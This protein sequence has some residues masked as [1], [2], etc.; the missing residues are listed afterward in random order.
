MKKNLL[1]TSFVMVF[2]TVIVGITAYN[3]TSD[4]TYSS[5]IITRSVAKGLFWEEI[6]FSID[7]QIERVGVYVVN[8]SLNIQVEIEDL[9]KTIKNRLKSLKYI[10][11]KTSS[12]ELDVEVIESFYENNINQLISQMI[13]EKNKNPQ[14]TNFVAEMETL[15]N[16]NFQI[17]K[18]INTFKT[19]A[20]PKYEQN[21]NQLRYYSQQVTGMITLICV[22]LGIILMAISANHLSTLYEQI[23]KQAKREK[24]ISELTTAVCS[25]FDL[26]VIFD[27]AIKE[28]AK[29]LNFD[30][31][32][33]L[34]Y[35]E[36]RGIGIC[37]EYITSDKLEPETICSIESI[38][39][40]SNPLL[41]EC[42]NTLKPV[43]VND[44]NNNSTY[45][46][47]LKPYKDLGIFSFIIVPIILHKNKIYGF[48]QL[49]NYKK[50]KA[51]TKENIDL[52]IDLSNQLAIAISNAQLYKST[53]TKTEE[54]NLL[55]QQLE[56][57][58]ID[59]RKINH[60]LIFSNE[61]N[62]K[63]QEAERLRIAQDLHD[64]IIQG[65]ISLIRKT[66]DRKDEFNKIEIH[67]ELKSTVGQIRK[68]CQQ[69]RP[70]ILD[71][72]GLYS[73]IEWLLDDLENYGIVP[74]LVINEEKPIQ[75]S[76]KVDLMI[77]RVIQE[78]TN[79]IK[80]HSKAS[81][82]W[83]EITCTEDGIKINLVDDGCGFEYNE[84]DSFKTLG[85]VGIKERI[86][87]VSG[88]LLIN[89]QINK[90]TN[91]DIFV[92]LVSQKFEEDAKV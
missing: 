82:A 17:S 61:L 62:V 83:L 54:A 8:P 86:K 78:L 37:N 35:T 75:I 26:E 69:L 64:E 27:I 59:I 56:K 55:A 76:A 1:I 68:I 21:I 4:W 79:N 80:K 10:S 19:F 7:K 9:N 23:E 43:T 71:D 2:L 14:K 32:V 84:N 50:S 57:N 92:P 89:S 91:I 36:N 87:S 90:G 46:V 72:L 63:I 67:E 20:F 66:D 13:E 51:W 85:I 41:D 16:Y 44:V 30:R 77:F 65:L 49:E 40:K 25:T 3:V 81:N 88:H 29:A 53:K 6:A 74:H 60:E 42:K 5:D 45:Q 39:S 70:S 38:I 31:C 22:L 12:E 73:A 15:R 11:N 47:E 48:I 28:L 58:L 33:I 34:E 18:Q 52:I 24:L